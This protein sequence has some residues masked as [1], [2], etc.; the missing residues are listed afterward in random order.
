MCLGHAD[1]LVQLVSR[2][3]LSL[4]DI[5]QHGAPVTGVAVHPGGALAA[6]ACAEGRVT[7]HQLVFTTV[8]GLYQDLYASR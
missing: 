6:F 2:E 8:H 7:V 5:A 4:A 3:G 1:G